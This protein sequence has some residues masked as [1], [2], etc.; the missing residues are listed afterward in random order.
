MDDMTNDADQA[1]GL[2]LLPCF[3]PAVQALAVVIGSAAGSGA[4][5]DTA[6]RTAE[7]HLLAL[8]RNAARD[9]P[10]LSHALDAVRS[11]VCGVEEISRLSSG[12]DPGRDELL[13]L[14]RTQGLLAVGFLAEILRRAKP[15]VAGWV[16]PKMLRGAPP[17]RRRVHRPILA[18][19]HQRST[20]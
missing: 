18:L 19:S 6:L 1:S 10:G 16:G 12:F 17:R 4:S 11:A 7:A 9:T 2:G 8:R 13:A 5:D 20:T 3:A 15:K 14:A